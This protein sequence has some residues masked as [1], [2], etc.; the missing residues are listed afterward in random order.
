MT[1]T[2]TP[3]T[4]VASLPLWVPAETLA[5]RWNV[6]YYVVIRLIKSGAL[7][8]RK[9]GRDYRISRQAVADYEAPGLPKSQ[10]KPEGFSAVPPVMGLRKG[11]ARGRKAKVRT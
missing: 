11:K 7:L 6:S 9:I 10:P 4:P 2:A 3:E 8:A 1:A 5:A